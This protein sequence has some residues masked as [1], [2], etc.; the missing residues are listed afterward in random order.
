MK[1]Q[2][3]DRITPQSIVIATV[4]VIIIISPSEEAE[5]A[6]GNDH[7]HKEAEEAE[8]TATYSNGDTWPRKEEGERRPSIS[9]IIRISKYRRSYESRRVDVDIRPEDPENTSH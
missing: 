1:I 9:T 2:I 8:A 5:N 3:V 6:G 7:E 4:I